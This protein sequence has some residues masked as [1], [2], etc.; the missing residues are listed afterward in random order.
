MKNTPDRIGNHTNHITAQT[1]DEN[2]KGKG[3]LVISKLKVNSQG[4]RH[5][6]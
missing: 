3:K 4:M 1:K 2:S 5:Y 6:K